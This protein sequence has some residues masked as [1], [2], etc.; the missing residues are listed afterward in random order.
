MPASHMCH[1]H[2]FAADFIMGYNP[3]HGY[4]ALKN[5]KQQELN[6]IDTIYQRL[7]PLSQGNS[8]VSC[9]PAAKCTITASNY[10]VGR[11]NSRLSFPKNLYS[12]PLRCDT[13]L[14]QPGNRKTSSPPEIS[15]KNDL[16]GSGIAPSTRNNGARRPSPGASNW[17]KCVAFAKSRNRD[18]FGH[19]YVTIST[20]M[21]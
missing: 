10:T 14:V 3:T 18:A 20:E 9:T 15:T 21:K 19:L 6:H 5:Y 7:L 2:G 12:S 13:S 8:A 17:S 4:T 11:T 16:A 1:E